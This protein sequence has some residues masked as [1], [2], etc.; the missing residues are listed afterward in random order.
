MKNKSC[1]IKSKRKSYGIFYVKAVYT[2]AT[3]RG[4]H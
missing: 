4:E 3:S 2:Y 1:Q